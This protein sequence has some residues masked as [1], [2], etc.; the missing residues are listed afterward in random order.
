MEMLQVV[1]LQ[2]KKIILVKDKGITMRNKLNS[3]PNL[4]N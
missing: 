3:L 1:R 2:I 4:E